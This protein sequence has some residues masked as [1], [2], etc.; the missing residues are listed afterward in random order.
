[1]LISPLLK[2]VL[3]LRNSGYV[4]FMDIDQGGLSYDSDEKASASW[5]TN[6]L[7][8]AMIF[9][10]YR[11]CRHAMHHKYT[12]LCFRSNLMRWGFVKYI[13][14]FLD[15]SF[16]ITLQYVEGLLPGAL[17]GASVRLDSPVR[18]TAIGLLQ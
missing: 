5:S 18:G 12:V 14:S 2:Y 1:M 10:L 15:T 3:E 11:T 13:M 9:S 17:L 4:R 6:R 16:S 7:G 8:P